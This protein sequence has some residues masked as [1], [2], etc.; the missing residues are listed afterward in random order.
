MILFEQ[1]RADP[2]N[3]VADDR[4]QMN[5]TGNWRQLRERLV[6]VGRFVVLAI[7]CFQATA[8]QPIGE[9]PGSSPSELSLLALP[10]V[11]GPIQIS[12]SF[13]LLSISQIRDEVEE[14]AFSGVLTLV[15][16]DARQAFDPAREGTSERIF[17]GAYQFNEMS[18]GWYPQVTLVNVSSQFD[19]RAVLLRVQ[20][21]GTTT[22]IEKIEAVAKV[23][24]DERRLP[25]DRQHLVL[26]FRVF[27]FDASEVVFH[28][29]PNATS[30]D[31][32]MN[33]LP[34]WT[35]E[36]ISASTRAVDVADAD[37]NDVA[38]A[39]L[40]TI[41]VKRKPMFMLRLVVLPMALIV[42][43]SWSVFWMDCSSVGDRMS[44]SFVGILAAV[45]YQIT[46]VGIVPNVSYFTLMNEFLNLSFLLMC[47][48]V[49]VNLC[50][51]YADRHG[52]DLGDRIDR[53][54]R[55]IFPLVYVG[56]NAIAVVV[57]FYFI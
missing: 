2:S 36:G 46:L 12:A 7:C 1:Y 23:D 55:W 48:T 35:V 37:S 14:V 26:V 4:S 25:F 18:P 9:S 31:D 51:A 24:L 11:D 22:L 8:A 15:W 21:D 5:S 57:T 54:C 49:V 20:P 47:A 16:R 10:A 29:D 53:Q 34:Q 13:Q 41:A 28:A 43:L 40:V 44:V 56:L 39:F 32:L 33:R 17:S 45:A 50:V 38:S 3:R 30:T 19:S 52:T 42:A 27:G 6:T